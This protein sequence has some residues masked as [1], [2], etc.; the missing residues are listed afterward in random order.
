MQ[1]RLST[2]ELTRSQ[3]IG[4]TPLRPNSRSVWTIVEAFLN[5]NSSL[6][7]VLLLPG[8]TSTCSKGLRK[9]GTIISTHSLSL[10]WVLLPICSAF[11][12]SLEKKKSVAD[13]GPLLVDLIP[14]VLSLTSSVLRVAYPP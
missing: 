4:C 1:F 12:S 14:R 10:T 11:D 3:W 8:P 2:N 7:T 13:E 5:Q 6:R 9:M